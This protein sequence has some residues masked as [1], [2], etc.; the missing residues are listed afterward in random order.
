MSKYLSFL[1]DANSIILASFLFLILAAIIIGCIAYKNAVKFYIKE[2]IAT[3]SNKDSYFSQKRII[4][5]IAIGFSLFISAYYVHKKIDTLTTPEF[6]W[7]LSWWLIIS[8]YN[9]TQ[10]QKDK[11]TDPTATK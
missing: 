2:L 8:G 9:V 3:C 4:N 7:I 10:I 1:A 11:V 5:W 6:M